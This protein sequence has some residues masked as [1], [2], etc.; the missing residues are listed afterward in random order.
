MT[1]SP[2]RR[3]K[4]PAMAV[5]LPLELEGEEGQQEAGPS[6]GPPWTQDAHHSEI[7]SPLL[8]EM[9]QGLG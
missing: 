8:L 7:G 6:C 1:S 9:G 5:S 2:T 3:K 4:T